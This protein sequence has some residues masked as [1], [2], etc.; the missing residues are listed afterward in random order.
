MDKVTCINCGFENTANFKYCQ[1]C[2]YE[3]PKFKDENIEEKPQQV[4]AS[5][6]DNKKKII[7]AMAGVF[8][9]YLS[10]WGV[11]QI[12]FRPPSFDKV[13]TE[14]AAQINKTCPIKVDDYSRLDSVLALPNNS[15]KYNY[16]LFDLTKAEVKLDTVKK[17][18]EPMILDKV[19]TEPKLKIYRDHKTT[20]IY[21]YNDKNGVFVYQFSV[22]PDLY[23]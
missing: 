22:T 2:G 11:Q 15:L 16:T 17:Y 8:A 10:Y 6:Q 5:K 18:M 12:F 9:F 7:G 14:A 1:G 13:M 21:S 19:R 4:N 23:Q 20:I 3:L